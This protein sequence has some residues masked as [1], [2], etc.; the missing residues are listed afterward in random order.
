MAF[1]YTKITEVTH[2]EN[3]YSLHVLLSRLLTHNCFMVA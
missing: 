1:L 2:S 3:Q